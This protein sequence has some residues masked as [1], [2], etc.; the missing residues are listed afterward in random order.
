MKAQGM[1]LAAA[2][3]AALAGAA[4][5]SAETVKVLANGIDNPRHVAVGPDGS[6]YVASAG[7]AGTRCQGKGEDETCIGMTS[8]VLRLS[9]D[10][11][12]TVV[13]GG[14]PSIGGPGGV[15]SVGIDG[16][17]VRPD[18]HVL[19]VMTSATP[20]EVRA[21]PA[22]VRSRVGRLFDVTG[23]ATT[24]LA[25]VSAYEW[26]NNPDRVRGDRNSNPYAVLALPDR[27]IVAD[28]GGNAVYSVAAD[29]ALSLL[30]V[31]P[32]NGKNQP[33]PSS[34]A[35]GPDGNVY[36]GELAEG[37]GRGKARVWRIPLT[38][39]ATPTVAASGFTTVTGLAFGPDRSMYVTELMT[40]PRKQDFAGDVVRVAPDGTR[41]RL[42]AGEL[43]APQGAAVDATGAL[44]VSNWS[45]L[46][47][48]TPK[49]GPFKGAGGQVVQ[50]TP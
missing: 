22:A 3:G 29:G 18:G 50:I 21:V 34:L 2:L 49:K 36:V 38:G 37:A 32:K 15:F 39:A 17:S 13:A 10:G 40:N 30:A 6:V 23:G 46:P 14:L 43:F 24:A 16:V 5:A 9:A 25:D 12:K 20:E 28:A 7:R 47:A 19:A 33:V 48:R 42:G 44:Y 31:I 11:A 41:T 1:V 27:T 35:L 8:R 26:A 4:T 45:V